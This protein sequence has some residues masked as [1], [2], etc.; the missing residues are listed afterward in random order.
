MIPER[1]RVIVDGVNVAKRHQ[2]ATGQT[3]QGGIIDKDMPLHVSNVAIVCS[4]CD[5][6][7]ASATASRATARRSGSAASAGRTSD[8]DGDRNDAAPEERYNDELRSTLQQELGLG[9]VMQVPRLEKIVLNCGVGQ[10]TQQ[11]SL[12]DGAVAD[13]GS[14]PARS[15]WSRGRRSR[16][17][18]SSSVRATRSAPR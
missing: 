2:R 4:G 1:D 7:P 5:S 3:M 16:S 12:L 8:G 17:P 14:S 11:A 10:A 13:L 18:A 15:R 6:R 9:N